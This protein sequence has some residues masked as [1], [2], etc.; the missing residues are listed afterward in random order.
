MVNRDVSLPSYILGSEDDED[1]S[2]VRQ[3]DLSTHST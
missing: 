2:V 3:T 1:E